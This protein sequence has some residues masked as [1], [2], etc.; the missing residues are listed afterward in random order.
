VG[1]AQRHRLRYWLGYPARCLAWL[2]PKSKSLARLVERLAY[3]RSVYGPFLL[4]T[5]GDRTFELCVG[6]YGRFISDAIERQRERFTFLDIGANLGLFSLLAARHPCCDRVIAVEPLPAI[7]RNLQAN[8]R[9]NGAGKVEPVL[10]AV[11]A[12]SGPFAYL[13]FNA[14]HSGMSKLTEVGAC[15]LRA[16]VVTAAGLDGLFSEPPERIVVKI[17]VE[18]SEIDVLTV[19]A[20]TRFYGA[21]DELII[22]VSERNLGREN[23]DRLRHR[24]AQD[25]FEEHSRA[26]PPEHCDALYRRATLSHGR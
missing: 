14:K 1:A 2:F 19:L 8:I 26:G 9:R 11:S 7:F 15:R 23:R 20:M 18:G 24:L 21:I 12:T 13:T 22:E 10:G 16:P 17:D 5:P 6:G 25:G 4:N 3:V